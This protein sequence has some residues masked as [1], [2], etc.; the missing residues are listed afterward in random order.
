MENS[1]DFTL[2]MTLALVAGIGAQVIGTF[3]RV[4]SIVFLLLFGL[5]L[6][7]D[8]LGLVRP[9]TLGV[10]LEVLVSLAVALILFEGGLNLKLQRLS[11]VSLSLRNLVTLGAALTLI[12]AAVAANLLSEFPWPL[13]FLYGSLVV[14]TGPT[15]VTPILRRVHVDSTVSTLLEGE[16]VLIDPI[17]AILAVV[18]L[19]VVL[20][21]QADLAVAAEQLGV[22][23]LVGAAIGALAGWL[24]GAFLLWSR[25]Y[26]TEDLRNSVVLAG[27]LAVFILAQSILSESGLMAVVIAG[28]VVRQKAAIAER[29]VRQFHSQLV[30]LAT[31]VLFILLTATVSIKAVLTLGWGAV[32]TVLLLMLVVRPLSVLLCTWKSDLNWRQK[33]F[34]AWMAPRGIVAA[35]IASLFAILLTERGISGGDALKALVFLTITMTVMIQGLT[36]PWVARWLDLEKGGCTV[37]VGN[38]PL[39]QGLAKLLRSQGQSVELVSLLSS[40]VSQIKPSQIKP[41]ASN[42]HSNGHHA[43]S[44]G[45]PLLHQQP[46]RLEPAVIEA[47]EKEFHPDEILNESELLKA[48]IEHADTLI[49]MTLNPQVNWAI[50][51]L[52]VKLF[53]SATVWTVLLPNMPVS[54]GIRGLSFSFEQMQRWGGYLDSGATQLRSI[55]LPMLADL[56]LKNGNSAVDLDVSAYA[57][58]G[59]RAFERIREHFTYRISS[60]QCLPLLL[61]RPQRGGLFSKKQTY[62]AFLLPEPEI[63]HRGDQVYFLERTPSETLSI[64]DDWRVAVGSAAAPSDIRV[65][66]D[67]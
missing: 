40:A 56:G 22:R 7:S 27:S 12:G 61:L 55:T 17:G 45:E 30:V 14:V 57:G 34:V 52:S 21:G 18:V 39:T 6:G 36:A 54:E 47:L 24:M 66:F 3:L 20:S 10:G 1:F 59:D 2:L 23:L 33:L 15:V 46:S 32:A 9:Q 31:S 53:S 51:E 5:L 16:G 62:R 49:V 29:S 50:A 13:A 43:Q 48:D 8:G 4:P 25:Q 44:S 37:I 35:S 28:M 38:H 42:G 11:Q 60:D 41:A 64:P 63:W 26:L 67:L 58:F 19:Q 65:Y